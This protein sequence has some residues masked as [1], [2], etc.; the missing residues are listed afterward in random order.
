MKKCLL[1]EMFIPNTEKRKGKY[2]FVG[3]VNNRD[4]AT[5]ISVSKE[6]KDIKFVIVSGKSNIS[7][8]GE[9]ENIKFY[10]E[11]SSKKYYNLMKNAYITVCPL[12][13]NKVSGLINIIKSIQ[14]GI[15]CISTNLYVTSKYYDNILREEL[16]YELC[17][18]EELKEK[19]QH[20]YE[21]S[22]EEY[23]KKWK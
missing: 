21:I 20:M 14:Y 5:L 2:V 23:I 11:I 4:W 10:E 13:E 19:I 6:M 17:D 18:K 22:S 1:N 12:K 16:L 15:P 9:Y 3:G 8:Q 7:Y